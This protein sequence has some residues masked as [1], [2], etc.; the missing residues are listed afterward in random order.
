MAES[1]ESGVKDETSGRVGSAR[2]TLYVLSASVW[3]ASI[4]MGIVWPL[5]PVYAAELGASGVQLGLVISTFSLPRALF[6]PVMGRVSDYWGRRPLL[7]WG[8]FLFTVVSVLYVAVRRVETLALVRLLHGFTSIMVVPVALA[9]T[10]DIAPEDRLGAYMGTMSMAIMLGLGV[11][12]VLGGAIRDSFGMD[13]AFYTMGGLSLLTFWAVR[14]FIPEDGRTTGAT[15]H[16]VVAPMKAVLGH[17]VVRGLFVLRFVMASG[18]GCVYTFLPL[19]A[20]RLHVDSSQVGLIL[21]ANVLLIATL[22]RV[23]GAVA[24]RV[25]PLYQIAV[26]T[27][28]SA[29]AVLGM[30]L[31]DGFLELLLLNV[32]MGVGSGISMPAGLALSGRV[33]QALGMGSVM[34]ILEAGWSAGMIA[35]PILSGL[36]MDAFDLTTIF[37][38]GG[39]VILVGTTFVFAYLRGHSTASG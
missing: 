36:I 34:G 17:R 2:R 16:R 1:S 27:S 38:V 9:K 5:V 20:L 13:A 12:P 14:R 39:G 7:L 25:N 19:L 35:S 24:D 30:P 21:G 22:Q 4:G 23:F 26:G 37:Y 33:G 3:A 18:Q 28:L 15:A 31:A 32:L 29:V 8:L 10:G 11:G 6:N